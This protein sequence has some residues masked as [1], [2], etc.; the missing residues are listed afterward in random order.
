MKRFFYLMGAVSFSFL[1]GACASGSEGTDPQNPEKPEVVDP[2]EEPTP[3]R[4]VQLKGNAVRGV[5]ANNE[6][7]FELWKQANQ[8]NGANADISLAPSSVFAVLSMM[9]NGDAGETRSE[10]LDLI[11]C[12][13][14]DVDIEA[15]NSYHN[16]MLNVL[17]E[18]DNTVALKLANSIWL[19]NSLTA[20]NS[21]VSTVGDSYYA[22]LFT[23]ALDTEEGKQQINQW[24]EENTNGMIKN[25][26]KSPQSGLQL[27]LANTLYFKGKWANPFDRSKSANGQFNGASKTSDVTF[28]NNS[29]LLPYAK[30]E[31]GE[32]ICLPYGNGNFQMWLVLPTGN[33]IPTF[34]EYIEAMKSYNMANVTLSLP[35]FEK[36]ANGN[37]LDLL[38]GLGL[39]KAI[40]GPGFK[41]MLANQQQ[42]FLGLLQHAVDIKVDE[43]GAEAGAAAFGGMISMPG[44]PEKFPDVTMS[45]NRPFHYILVESSTGAILMVGSVRDL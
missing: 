24:V 12:T 28:M 6:F 14:N 39:S 40:S 5:D 27:G 30:T 44:S 29:D 9:A 15:L 31:N 34:A 42:L 43:E 22:P 20:D 8:E 18:L 36:S 35:R 3:Y 32:M 2:T 37:I 1:L 33:D 11:R 10:I 4:Q 38:K 17:P 41:N 19:D 21:F 45:F 23:C 25:F 26:L 13:D 16:T 7:A